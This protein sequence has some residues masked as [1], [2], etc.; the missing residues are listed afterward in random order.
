[1]IENSDPKIGLSIRAGPFRSRNGSRLPE[2][3]RASRYSSFLARR[4]G[5]P[6]RLFFKFISLKFTSIQKPRLSAIELT[7]P[8][9]PAVM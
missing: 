2:H 1:V 5:D 4:E 7:L 9:F 3:S 6:V 8:K